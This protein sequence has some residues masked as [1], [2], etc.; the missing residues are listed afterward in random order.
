MLKT[1]LF[2]VLIFSLSFTSHASWE[3]PVAGTVAGFQV[4]GPKGAALGL[5]VG[6][7][8]EIFVSTGLFE[9]RYLASGALGAGLLQPMGLSYHIHEGIGFLVG[10]LFATG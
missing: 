6:C 8:D 10:L 1:P 3:A 4:A 5:L 7:A 2:F 9:K